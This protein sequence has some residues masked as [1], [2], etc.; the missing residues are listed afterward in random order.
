MIDKVI[1]I[2]GGKNPMKTL[3]ID[4]L[5]LGMVETELPIL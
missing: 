1:D 4:T 2:E 3:K 5:V